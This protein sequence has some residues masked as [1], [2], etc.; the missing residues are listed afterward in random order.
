MVY[1][2]GYC[3]KLANICNADESCIHCNKGKDDLHQLENA[4]FC[5]DIEKLVL[6]YYKIAKANI[7]GDEDRKDVEWLMGPEGFSRI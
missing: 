6:P 1:Q 3:G 2:C 7:T 5:D 4:C